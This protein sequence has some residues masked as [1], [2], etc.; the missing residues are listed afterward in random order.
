MRGAERP[1][2]AANGRGLVEFR[3]NLAMEFY[4]NSRI[5]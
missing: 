5:S 2:S 1:A 4:G 3:R